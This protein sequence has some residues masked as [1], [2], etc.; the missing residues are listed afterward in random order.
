MIM[1]EAS[2]GLVKATR[3]GSTLIIYL[4][5]FL[6]ATATRIRRLYHVLT[7]DYRAD[8]M[9]LLDVAEAIDG[10]IPGELENLTDEADVI[11]KE[12]EDC[13]D[14]KKQASLEKRMIAIR[15]RQTQLRNGVERNAALFLELI[16]K[17]N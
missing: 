4:P 1:T 15:K 5:A 6:P 7:C 9:E 13:Y 8:Y 14:A 17:D 16:Q 2:K 3:P 11:I 10:A 12:L